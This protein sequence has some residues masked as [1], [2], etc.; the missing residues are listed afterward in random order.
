VTTVK[1]AGEEAGMDSAS[2]F[3]NT[4]PFVDSRAA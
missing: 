4:Y 2:A 3:T 1:D